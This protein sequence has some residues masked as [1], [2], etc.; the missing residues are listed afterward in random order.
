MIIIKGALYV[1]L[2]IN[3]SF[4]MFIYIIVEVCLV[5]ILAPRLGPSVAMAAE[6][7]VRV[8][9]LVIKIKREHFD[10]RLCVA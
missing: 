10:F 9:Q 8:S 3:H 2:N 7:F 5:A 1:F 6:L 4:Q